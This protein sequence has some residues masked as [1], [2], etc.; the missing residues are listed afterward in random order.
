MVVNNERITMKSS[1]LLLLV[2]VS[3]D[4]IAASA[5]E[6]DKEKEPF[7]AQLSRGVIRLEHVEVIHREKAQEPITRNV[8]DGTAFFVTSSSE[9]YVVSARHV[10]E[11]PYDLHA[12]VQSKIRKTGEME[13]ILLELPRNGW[14][15]HENVGDADTRFVD[16]A[17][18]KIPWIKDR[19][20][21]FFRYEQKD[22]RDYDK[23]Q[24]PFED[25]EPPRPILVFGFPGD[26]GF[27]LLEQKPVGR[28]GVI[29]MRT[30]KEFL[31]VDAEKFAE[32]RCCLIDARMFP[33]NSGSPVMNQPRF[34]EPQPE[35]LGLVIACNK[36]LDFGVIEPVSRIRE[37]LD[38][39]T[40]R[41]KSGQWKLLTRQKNDNPTSATD[42]K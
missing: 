2:L 4:C 5:G 32:E 9:L 33:G 39:A 38:L 13:V 6:E 26:V 35:V 40:E 20:I 18:M 11:K 23:N 24:L 10:V 34:G 3:L 41:A 30:G 25:A 31:K 27:E 16:V 21:K 37:T 36:A 12:R 7:Y 42:K 17:V 19:S 28:L 14:V 1:Q 29:S 15:Y 22:S 8:P